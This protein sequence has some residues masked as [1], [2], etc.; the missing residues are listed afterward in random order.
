MSGMLTVEEL[1]DL[2]ERG[3][4]DTVICA[5][6]DHW[7]RL[8]GKRLRTQTFFDVALADEG[9]HGSLFLLCVDMEMEPRQGYAL[10]GWESGF[11][12]FRFVPDLSTLRLIP[13]QHKTALVICDA[14]EENSDTLVEVAPRTILRRQIERARAL[15]LSIKCATELEFYLFRGSLDEAWSTRYRDLLPTSRYRSDYHVFQGTLLEDF[16]REVREGLSGAG[17]DIEFSKPEWGLG[18]Q[19]INARYTDALTMA[20]RHAIFKMGVKEIAVKHGLI[21]TFMAKPDIDEVGSSCHVHVSLWD[22]AGQVPTGWDPGRKHNIS[23]T[24]EHFLGGSLAGTRELAVLLAPTVNSYKR[25][26][27]E[28]FAPTAIAIGI[29]NRTCSHRI[30]GHGPS[31]RFENRIPGADVHPHIALAGLLAAGLH[32]ITGKVAAPRPLAGN[33]YE[34]ATLER[35]PNTLGD[36]VRGFR[37]SAVAREAFG[38]QVH[39]HLI[40]FY[41]IENEDFLCRTVTDWERMRYFERI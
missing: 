27:P 21:A 1:R 41:A 36:A 10:T 20:D 30:I 5:V 28:S 17:L 8:V 40:N 14:W 25:I 32:G 2:H 9:L 16:T 38:P 37:D 3:E 6:P 35:I 12:D 26:Q 23:E 22:S 33:A 15:D 18:Q 19:E 24:L 34:D 31:F 7:G 29:D 39:D 11:P 13:W 4:V